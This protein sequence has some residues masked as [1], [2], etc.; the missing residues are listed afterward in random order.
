MALPS[1]LHPDKLL[2]W[3]RL[4]WDRKVQQEPVLTDSVMVRRGLIKEQEGDSLKKVMF[5]GLLGVKIKIWSR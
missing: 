2:A 4:A 3:G 5:G 1:L